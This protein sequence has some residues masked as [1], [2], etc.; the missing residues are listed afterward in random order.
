M[1]VAAVE[2]VGAQRPARKGRDRHHQAH[3]ARRRR[4]HC[5]PCRRCRRKPDKGVRTRRG[6]RAEPNPLSSTTSVQLRDASHCG[7]RAADQSCIPRTGS[8]S[9]AKTRDRCLCKARLHVAWGACRAVVSDN[10]DVAD[11]AL[12]S[13][14]L[15]RC[16]RRRR[17]SSLVAIFVAMAAQITWAGFQTVKPLGHG[18]GQIPHHCGRSHQGA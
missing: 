16:E 5:P 12:M 2:A 9:T 17:V 11:F 8:S 10:R 14:Q 3:G 15:I 6:G 4:C 7:R 1:G 13:S 18:V